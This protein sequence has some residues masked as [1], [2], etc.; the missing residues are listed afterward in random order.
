MLTVWSDVLRDTHR[1]RRKRSL[2]DLKVMATQYIAE[3]LANFL[4]ID[5]P[6]VA[7]VISVS[8]FISPSFGP[9]LYNDTE[10]QLK[11]TARSAMSESTQLSPRESYNLSAKRRLYGTMF[12][13]QR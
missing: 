2:S 7:L 3:F 12:Q 4:L 8:E 13:S 6:V 1:G 5:F 9:K 11:T 10:G